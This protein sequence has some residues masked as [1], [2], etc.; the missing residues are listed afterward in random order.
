MRTSKTGNLE[1]IKQSENLE[2]WNGLTRGFGSRG[3]GKRKKN[4]TFIHTL[5][6]DMSLQLQKSVLSNNVASR[7]LFGK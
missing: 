6:S 5:P 4:L 7:K 2:G 1:W 3:E